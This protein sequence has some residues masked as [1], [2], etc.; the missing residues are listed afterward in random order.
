MKI[1]FFFFFVHLPLCVLPDLA[2]CTP[3]NY[4]NG[5]AALSLTASP[6]TCLLVVVVLLCKGRIRIDRILLFIQRIAFIKAAHAH[7]AGNPALK[8]AFC[9]TQARIVDRQRTWIRTLRALTAAAAGVTAA[10]RTVGHRRR[11]ILTYADVLCPARSKTARTAAILIT[12]TT[13]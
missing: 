3:K 6:H 7:A 5:N 9:P 4:V 8:I 1:H 2:S 11:D 10:V 13:H 12:I